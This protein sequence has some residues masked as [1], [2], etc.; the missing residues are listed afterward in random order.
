MQEN[1]VWFIIIKFVRSIPYRRRAET[2]NCHS[3][4]IKQK[5]SVT[6]LGNGI[7]PPKNVALLF[8]W[9]CYFWIMPELIIKVSTFP[10]SHIWKIRFDRIFSIEDNYTTDIIITFYV[11]FLKI[12]YCLPCML[13]SF[14][15]I[16]LLQLLCTQMH[17]FIL[18]RSYHCHI[19][20]FKRHLL[21]YHSTF[22][23]K[24]N[25][26]FMYRK[27]RNGTFE[28]YK[29]GSFSECKFIRCYDRIILRQNNR[30]ISTII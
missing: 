22:I 16:P 10:N 15:K 25:I 12:W 29:N 11:I 3:S 18:D 7:N 20:S 19:S 1:F 13:P 8:C 5:Q 21:T 2:Q 14:V 6:F 24:S 28:M 26:T 17:P 23:K 30:F 4:A 9:K 27:R